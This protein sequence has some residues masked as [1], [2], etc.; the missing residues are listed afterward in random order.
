MM[1]QH[2]WLSSIVIGISL[3]AC[4]TD[5]R[6]GRIPNVLT[7]GA[8]S[9]AFLTQM[10]SAG[11]D[12]ATSAATGWFVGALLFMPFFAVG[13]MGGGDVK[14][15]AALGAW[16]GPHETFWLAVYS[17]I[18]GGVCGVAVALAKGYLSTAIRNVGAMVFYWQ[19]VGIRPVPGL[20]LET[21]NSP[22]LAYAIPIFIGVVITLWQ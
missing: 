19:T 8:A 10:F 4:I 16:L 6:S 7:I 14:L 15:L 12:G 11:F 22:R 17:G 18:A 13:G 1:T 21:C 3:V 2:L 5:V 9:G 20:T